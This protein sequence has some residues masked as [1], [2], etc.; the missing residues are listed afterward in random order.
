MP[1]RLLAA[2]AVAALVLTAVVPRAS[3]GA[4]ESTLLILVDRSPSMAAGGK[5]ATASLAI[6]QALD[7][8]AVDAMSVGLI[9]APS[10]LVTAPVCDCAVCGGCP[11]PLTF[12]WPCVAPPLPQ[13]PI[14]LAGT[15]KST[16][17]SGVRRNIKD[18]LASSPPDSAADL[19]GFPLYD[20]AV[21][22]LNALSATPGPGPRTLL[23]LT[24]GGISCGRFA[25]PARAGY[26]DCNGCANG[27]TRKI[28]S[29]SLPTR[30]TVP[31]SRS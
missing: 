13:V 18:W 1:N 27:N 21:S 24:D 20:A 11:C 30:A 12:L 22:A 19:D 3:S 10:G 9:A 8:D 17:Q 4:G 7:D 14:A 25:N 29:R 16:A 28:S 15:E 5:W 31:R 6:V 23:V 2:Y 26:T